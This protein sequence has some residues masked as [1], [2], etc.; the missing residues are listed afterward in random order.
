MGSDNI[1]SSIEDNQSTIRIELKKTSIRYLDEFIG[2][3]CAVDLLIAGIYPDVKEI[4]EAFGAYHA[5]THCRRLINLGDPSVQ[6]FA[7]ADGATP[8]CGALFAFRSAWQ[9]Y[10]IDPNMQDKQSSLDKWRQINRLETH[11]KRWE[12]FAEDRKLSETTLD[13]VVVTAIHSHIRLE[14][15]VK[16]FG[17][18]RQ[19][20]LIAMPCCVELKLDAKPYMS[21]ADWAVNSP[22]RHVD[23]YHGKIEKGIFK[24]A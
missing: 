23:I 12:D 19:I 22:K 21:Y 13:K 10:S 14:N 24:C 15:I 8:R 1:L 3:K 7:V 18:V 11:R 2:L 17:N 4:T 16:Y 9:C 20:I 6:L 5:V